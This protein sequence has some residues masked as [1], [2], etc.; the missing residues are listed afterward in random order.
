MRENIANR[1]EQ[2]E[3]SDKIMKPTS[4]PTYYEDL[5]KELEEAPNRS[6]F[7]QQVNKWKGALRFQ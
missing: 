1:N 4:N 6:W 7:Q 3:L 5:M 2:Y